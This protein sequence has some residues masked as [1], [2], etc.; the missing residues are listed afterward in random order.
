[1]LALLVVA[2]VDTVAAV[3]IAPGRE[4]LAVQLEAARV[5][6]VAVLLRRQRRHRR[7]RNFWARPRR[8]LPA[9]RRDHRSVPHFSANLF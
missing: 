9:R 8:V 6:A 5:F 3:A 4:A 7:A 2:A 1:M